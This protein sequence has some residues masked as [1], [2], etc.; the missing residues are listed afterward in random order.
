MMYARMIVFLL[1]MVAL[2]DTWEKRWCLVSEAITSSASSTVMA[3]T[4]G[5]LCKSNFQKPFLLLRL[6]KFV[7]GL[8]NEL[9][10]INVPNANSNSAD[11][12]Q[13]ESEMQSLKIIAI[14]LFFY[15]DI[16]IIPTFQQKDYSKEF[17]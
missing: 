8:T 9:T 3:A 16:I 17:H 15:C 2:D 13:N 12:F 11:A 4:E 6:I 10:N 5:S 1:E 14:I 7:Q